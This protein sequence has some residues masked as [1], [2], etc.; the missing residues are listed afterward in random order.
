MWMFLGMYALRF[1]WGG[2][3]LLDGSEVEERNAR[4]YVAVT[5]FFASFGSPEERYE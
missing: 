3:L 2:D 5:G 4:M 1:V